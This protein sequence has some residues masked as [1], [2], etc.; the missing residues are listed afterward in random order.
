MNGRMVVLA[1]LGAL[2]LVVGGVFA[3]ALISGGRSYD[4]GVEQPAVE[5]AP[6]PAAKGAGEVHETR[7]AERP[8]PSDDG[9]PR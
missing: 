3:L 7:G 4:S 8:A 5:R 6:Q 1:L 2:V 9:A